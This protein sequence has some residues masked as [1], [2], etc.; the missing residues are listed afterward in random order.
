MNKGIMYLVDYDIRTGIR[1]KFYRALNRE[2]ANYLLK[3]NNFKN[4][5]EAKEFLKIRGIYFKSSLSVILTDDRKI[6]EIVYNV[7]Q[8]YGFANFYI[9]T[10]VAPNEKITAT[11]VATQNVTPVASDKI[12][13]LAI[14]FTN[15]MKAR[16]E[17]REFLRNLAGVS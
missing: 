14:N 13:D 11:P 1:Y 8:S 17:T 6:A 3:D 12:V 10:P 2:L 5:N 15:W 7:A 16:E 9:V 4:L